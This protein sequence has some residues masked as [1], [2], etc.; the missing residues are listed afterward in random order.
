MTRSRLL[1]AAGLLVV[2]LIVRA[3]GFLP[4]VIN[5]D[6]SVF[7]LAAREV[8]HGHLP[9]LTFFDNKPVG[10]TLI[11]A[12]AFRLLGQSIVT[13]R[14]V[15]ALFVWASA[16]G[17]ALLAER[18]GLG[19]VQ[20]MLCAL[21]YVVFTAMIG[22]LATLTEILLAPFTILAVLLLQRQLGEERG[23]ARRLVLAGA[24]G[25]TCGAA[26]L[27]K[28]VPIVPGFAVAAVV[29]ALLV[30]RRLASVVQGLLLLVIFGVASVVPMIL[31][32][33]VYA[34]A[35]R[36]PD[37]LYSNFGFARAYAAIHPGPAMVAQRLGT[38][39]DALWPLL[40]LAVIALVALVGG[41]RRK[42][43]VPDLLLIATAWLAGEVV[44]ASASLQFFPHYFLTAVPPLVV[45]AGFAIQTI[46]DWTG[47]DRAEAEPTGA[48]G[49]RAVLVLSGIVA[50]IAIERA[51]V[52][53][54][55]DITGGKDPSKRIAA[56]IRQAS[57]GHAPTLFVTSYRLT[58][59][60]SLTGA[61]LPP[62]RYAVPAHLLSRQSAMIRADPKVEVA[63]ILASHPGY[64]VIDESE[65]LPDWA[66]AQFAAVL[67]ARYRP[68]YAHDDV[69]V[70]R[71]T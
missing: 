26:V 24:A 62:T 69:K 21:L 71:A 1:F 17:V 2:V 7:A 12:A 37:Y 22:G 33:A 49:W 66:S 28:I 70:Y 3:I 41:W 56:A 54:A 64:V 14:L 6:E 44:A 32:A 40:G 52:D 10:S 27:I 30:R 23:F 25:L 48:H 18:G 31:G 5:P 50:L 47:M 9:Y 61:P 20:A 15:G 11:L 39:I 4:G 38:M 16:L 51:E 55:R 46:I 68:F 60:Y 59:L 42:R 53:A 8:V 58:A 19:R 13:L 34:G 57:G 67:A 63:R 35:G 36:L 43:A 65:H 29:C 45:L